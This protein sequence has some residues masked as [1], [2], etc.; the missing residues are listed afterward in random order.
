MGSNCFVLHF[1]WS[2]ILFDKTHFSPLLSACESQNG[3]FSSFFLV[4]LAGGSKP[5]PAQATCFG[6][7]SCLGSFVKRASF[8]GF[9]WI[10][11]GLNQ[12]RL[13]FAARMVPYATNKGS[14]HLFGPYTGVEATKKGGDRVVDGPKLAYPTWHLC[15]GSSCRIGRA[16]CCKEKYTA[17]NPE[18]E[19]ACDKFTKQSYDVL[20]ACCLLLGGKGYCSIWYKDTLCP[21][22]PQLQPPRGTTHVGVLRLS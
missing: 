21:P 14:W 19:R 17:P 11:F 4:L 7:P 2:K 20:V 13:G 18:P 16:T 15:P 8:F 5:Y 22:P 9:R 12:F 3:A 10:H 6:I 1:K